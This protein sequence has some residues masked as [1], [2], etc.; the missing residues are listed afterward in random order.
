MT[1]TSISPGVIACGPNPSNRRKR[2]LRCPMCEC[3]TETVVSFGGWYGISC[4]C[5]RCGDG[6][7]DGEL[8]ER[9]FARGWRKRAIARHRRMWDEATH[10]PEPT[11]YE[12]G[13]GFLEEEET[14]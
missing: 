10:G 3:I 12:Q 13:I 2:Y 7:C 14:A 6:W 8:Y 11:L 4:F 9:P 1:C 5:C